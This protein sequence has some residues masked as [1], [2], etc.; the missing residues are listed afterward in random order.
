MVVYLICIDIESFIKLEV[1]ISTSWHAHV[2]C[3]H[4]AHGAMCAMM[5]MVQCVPWCMCNG[6]LGAMCASFFQV[7]AVECSAWR[8]LDKEDGLWKQSVFYVHLCAVWS[9][10]LYAMFIYVL[11]AM[12]SYMHLCAMC[13]L[14]SSVVLDSDG[15]VDDPDAPNQITEGIRR[16]PPTLYIRLSFCAVVAEVNAL[17]FLHQ[18]PTRPYCSGWRW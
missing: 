3:T 7:H 10:V 16:Q 14:C 17:R 12:C 8:C 6:V 15:S 13:T 4:G 18:P 1:L 9:Y 5:Y 11:C 2:H